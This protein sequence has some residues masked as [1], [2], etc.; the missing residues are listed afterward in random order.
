MRC[1][2]GWTR[3]SFL[4]DTARIKLLGVMPQNET[5]SASG[6]EMSTMDMWNSESERERVRAVK[7]KLTKYEE[8]D[9]V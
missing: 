1:V 7:L 8:V 5:R 6:D 9:E 3:V 2:E 4:T